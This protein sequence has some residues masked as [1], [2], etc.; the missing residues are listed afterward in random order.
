MT[1]KEAQKLSSW[2]DAIKQLDELNVL[3]N[4]YGHVKMYNDDLIILWI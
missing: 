3:D 1:K 4:V 2:I